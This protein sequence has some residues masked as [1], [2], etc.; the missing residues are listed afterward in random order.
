M[1]RPSLLEMTAIRAAR[2][3]FGVGVS[4]MND[5]IEGAAAKNVIGMDTQ[6][7]LNILVRETNPGASTFF[8]SPGKLRPGTLTSAVPIAPW[9][10][11]FHR[12]STSKRRHVPCKHATT[13]SPV[14]L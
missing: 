8:L 12:C 5:S 9:L 3:D 6:V 14:M 4:K 13:E 1:L 7:S 2:G 10:N 11:C